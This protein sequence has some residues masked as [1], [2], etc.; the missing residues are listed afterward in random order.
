MQGKARRRELMC[1]EDQLVLGKIRATSLPR[2]HQGNPGEGQRRWKTRVLIMAKKEC[3]TLRKVL[4]TNVKT[5]HT[6]DTD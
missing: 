3:N 1:Q 6:Y 2:G 5:R 4:E